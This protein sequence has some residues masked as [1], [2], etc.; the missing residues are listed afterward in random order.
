MLHQP[1]EY[2]LIPEKIYSKRYRLVDNSTLAKVLFYNIAHQ[3]RLP[4]GIS[5][6]D[7]DNCYDRVAHLIVS[8]VFQALKVPQEATVSLLSTIQDMKFFLQTGYGDSKAYAHLTKGKKTQGLYQGNGVAP[9]GWTFTSITKIQA[10][11][12]KGHG[13]FM[14]CPI[15]KTPLHLVGTLFVD[16]ANHEHFD[17]KKV[18]IVV[19][20]HTALALQESIHNWGRILI[21]TGGAL[22]AAKCFYHL[23]SFSWKADGTWQYDA[24]EWHPNLCIMVSLEDGTLAVIKNFPVITTTKT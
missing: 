16:E 3:M 21:A 19:K 20:V 9:A 13:V 6:V 10:H 14:L 2:K 17:M 24:N 23:I 18:E 4:A 15:T 7:A 8:L 1:R 5:A 22:K 11:K 12:R